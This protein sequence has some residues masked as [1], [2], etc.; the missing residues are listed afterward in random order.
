MAVHKLNTGAIKWFKDPVT[1]KWTYTKDK[2]LTQR[3]KIVRLGDILDRDPEDEISDPDILK[4]SGSHIDP[5]SGEFV[6]DESY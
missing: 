3:V 5:E 1:R 2:K 6:E 4:E